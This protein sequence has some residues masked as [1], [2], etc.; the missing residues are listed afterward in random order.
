MRLQVLQEDFSKALSISSRFVSNR[1]QLPILGNVHLSTDHNRLFIASTNLE[2][3]ISLNIGAKV[4]TDGEITVPS[5]TIHE[6]ISNL[7]K[8]QL[9]IV[10]EKEQL[11]IISQGSDATLSGIN[12]SE[13]PVVPREIGKRFSTI[14]KSVINEALSQVLFAA[15]VDETRPVLTG[16]LCVIKNGEVALV[17]TD[18]FRLS[19]RKI[20]GHF[21]IG[22]TK[23]ER[24]IIPKGA[25]IE[26]LR[27]Q[28]EEPD[29]KFSFG[30]KDNQAV[31]GTDDALL[32]SR[33][34]EGEF[35]QFE[36]II[37]KNSLYKIWIDREDL[38][39]AVK[40]AGVFARD[41]SN[42]LYIGIRDKEIEITS[43]S[44]SS[45]KQSTKLD[46]KLEDLSHAAS[47]KEFTI[48]FNFRF[49]EE[50]LNSVKGEEVC[51]EF[52]DS[53]AAGV[54]LDPKVPDYLHLI[55]PVKTQ[56]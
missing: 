33:I 9:E 36:K 49:L 25:L 20:A 51:M 21:V 11:K 4:A 10:A 23:E 41:A 29:L 54:F 12:A 22:D 55:M 52:S 16:I 37:P 31:F 39:R 30:G 42:V 6:I 56:T 15:S 34:I 53:N 47:V 14:P 8:G 28:S 24:I 45:G 43:E 17:A 18:G 5:K 3:A 26:V 7:P 13:F 38:L 48:A 2:M 27:I 50:F 46:V 44:S 1:A 35:P 40:L 19:Q 32:T